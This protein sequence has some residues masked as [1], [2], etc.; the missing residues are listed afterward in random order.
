MVLFFHVY[1]VMFYFPPIH[2]HTVTLPQVNP[3][4]PQYR[5]YGVETEGSGVP[6]PAQ[7]WANLAVFTIS[8]IST[9]GYKV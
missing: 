6:D 1:S 9:R 2:Q 8:S 3:C 5:C 7:L 4:L